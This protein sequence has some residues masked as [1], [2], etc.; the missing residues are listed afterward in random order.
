MEIDLTDN[1]AAAAST[2][3]STVNN[4]ASVSANMLKLRFFSFRSHLFQFVIDF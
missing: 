3:N 1:D 2:T 4:G